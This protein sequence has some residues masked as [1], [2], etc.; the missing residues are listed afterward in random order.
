R[1]PDRARRGLPGIAAQVAASVPARQPPQPAPGPCRAL[2]LRTAPTRDREDGL[3]PPARAGLGQRRA[4]HAGAS[5]RLTRSSG[6]ALL[7]SGPLDLPR[8]A[9]SPQV[10]GD[11]DILGALRSLVDF[12]LHFVGVVA[13]GDLVL[14][15]ARLAIVGR[16]DLVA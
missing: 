15:V 16:R 3:D 8:R 1:G 10:G 2:S 4:G 7:A 12:H 9:R 5:A 11:V 14:E 13:L 6:C